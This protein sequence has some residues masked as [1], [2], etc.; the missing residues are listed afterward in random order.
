MAGKGRPGAY[1]G[2]S[3]TFSMRMS[4]EARDLLEYHAGRAGVSPATYMRWVLE[5]HLRAQGHVLRPG[6]EAMWPDWAETPEGWVMA[7]TIDE[8]KAG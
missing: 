3:A 2:R 6:I 4:F 1:R 8:D 5:D 7:R